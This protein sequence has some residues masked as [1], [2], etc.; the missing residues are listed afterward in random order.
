[1]H[2]AKTHRRAI[3]GFLVRLHLEREREG[4]GERAFNGEIL[5]LLSTLLSSSGNIFEGCWLYYLGK[6]QQFYLLRTYKTVKLK[7]IQ[8]IFKKMI[9][10]L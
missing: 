7:I 6:F 9:L 1:M 10:W 2:I 3:I 4:N 5:G 8:R